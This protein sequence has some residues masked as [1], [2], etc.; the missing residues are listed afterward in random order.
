MKRKRKSKPGLPSTFPALD[1]PPLQALQELPHNLP[2]FHSGLS[3]SDLAQ[4]IFM[5]R[6]GVLSLPSSGV[7]SVPHMLG[8]L[9]D[10]GYSVEVT[11]SGA[12]LF[13]AG[14][15]V[16]EFGGFGGF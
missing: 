13:S 4:A 14:S 7:D 15:L 12:K 6:I 5:D 1:V 9:K 16:V 2:L 10:K 8:L 3:A 11:R